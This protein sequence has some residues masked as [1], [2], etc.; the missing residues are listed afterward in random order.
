MPGAIISTMDNEKQ[1]Q[2]ISSLVES[3]LTIRNKNIDKLN[4]EEQEK[5]HR[6]DDHDKEVLGIMV[7]D[8]FVK[9]GY[10]INDIIEYSSASFYCYPALDEDS[11][12][13]IM[14]RIATKYRT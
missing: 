3:L 11:A 4:D 8:L 1:E 9:K 14:D 12:I 10:S 7:R 13:K 5:A 6:D 2:I